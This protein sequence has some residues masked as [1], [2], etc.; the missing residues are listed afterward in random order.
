[1][2]VVCLS[3]YYLGTLWQLNMSSMSLVLLNLVCASL[4]F[5]GKKLWSYVAFEHQMLHCPFGHSMPIDGA[6]HL[7]HHDVVCQTPSRYC[8]ISLSLQ[9]V[10]ETPS[11]IKGITSYLYHFIWC[12]KLPL[13]SRY[14]LIYVS[15]HLLCQTPSQIKITMIVHRQCILMINKDC[16]SLV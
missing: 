9:M 4:D 12:V 10:Y 5:Y 1:M 7:Y 13:K 15:I 2:F 14:C 11:Q 3:S 16:L 8:L 6:W